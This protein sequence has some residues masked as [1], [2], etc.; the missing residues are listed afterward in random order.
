MLT[1]KTEEY[2]T[3]E[4][5]SDCCI[6]FPDGLFG[7]PNLL[8][9]LPLCL[10]DEEDSTLLV[11]QSTED[12]HIGFVVINPFALVEE[13]Q[14]EL[15]PEELSYLHADSADSLTFY[16]ICV[17]KNNCLDN[18]VNLKCPIVVNPDTRT[19]MQVI[20]N[21]SGYSFRHKLIEFLH[22][23]PNNTDGEITHADTETKEK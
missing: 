5:E 16:V 15:T 10:N 17:L 6:N 22:Q 23:N 14:P 11:L 8:E 7:F 3:L 1:L 20:L 9:Y 4:Y 2:G 18:T 19:G 12:S 21:H 13:Y